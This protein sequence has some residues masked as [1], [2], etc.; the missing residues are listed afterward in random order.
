MRY[1]VRAVSAFRRGSVAISTTESR[2]LAIP[3]N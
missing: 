2:G 1:R 3:V